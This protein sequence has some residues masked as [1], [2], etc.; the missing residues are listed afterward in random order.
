MKSKERFACRKEEKF[1]KQHRQRCIETETDMLSDGEIISRVTWRAFLPWTLC[2][3]L[4]R[5]TLAGLIH[6]AKAFNYTLDG[7]TFLTALVLHR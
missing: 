4:L 2:K 6:Q 7:S 1:R 5:K 3:N